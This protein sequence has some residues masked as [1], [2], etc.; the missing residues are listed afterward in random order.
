MFCKYNLTAL[1]CLKC[2]GTYN[3]TKWKHLQIVGYLQYLTDFNNFS[4]PR[5]NYDTAEN[6]AL[7][8]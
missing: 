3:T 2:S 5:M 8:L 6:S 7:C 1:L 4:H